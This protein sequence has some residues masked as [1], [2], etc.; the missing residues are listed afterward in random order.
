MPQSTSSPAASLTGQYMPKSPRRT[1]NSFGV[2][3]RSTTDAAL[4]SETL[5]KY[6]CRNETQSSYHE[7]YE[8][9]I[10]FPLRCDCF[11]VDKPMGNVS[12]QG[13]TLGPQ[14]NEL[15]STRSLLSYESLGSS[16]TGT[17]ISSNP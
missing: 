12:M 1:S 6:V 7:T 4:P 8:I 14:L 9:H 10:H 5:S 13:I 16:R 2:M 11:I 15:Q 3:Q 17:V